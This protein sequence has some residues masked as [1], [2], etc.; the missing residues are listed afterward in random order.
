MNDCAYGAEMHYLRLEN[1]PVAQAMFPDVDYAPVAEAFG[2]RTATIRTL[3]QLHEAAPLL[4]SRD[5]GPVL[6]D[7]K[8]N[9]AICGPY[10]AE[11]AGHLKK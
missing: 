2:F 8:I 5:E 11:A 1:M 7:C 3:A 9:A 4:R 6:L 10:I